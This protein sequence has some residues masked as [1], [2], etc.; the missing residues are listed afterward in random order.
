M[1]IGG[2]EQVLP[3]PAS[4]HVSDALLAELQCKA[5]AEGKSVDQL[6]EEAVRRM[7]DHK[8]LD[9]LARRGAAHAERVGRKNPVAAVRQVRRG[10]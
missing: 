1:F 5:V 9:E 2:L 6:T 4:V 3:H 7:L 8:A 10:R